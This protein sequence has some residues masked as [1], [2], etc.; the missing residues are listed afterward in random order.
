MAIG[1]RRAMEVDLAHIHA[2]ALRYDR[3]YSI[4]SLDTDFFKKYND[5]YGHAGGDGALRYT[6]DYLKAHVRKSDRIYRYGGE[7]VLLV[8]PQ[9]PVA[10]A[11]GLARRL[12][13][14]LDD[15]AEPHAESDDK[16][17]GWSSDCGRE[18]L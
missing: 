5:H 17:R 8:L 6:G 4:V 1:N 10:D 9:A 12:V 2:E 13:S 16:R 3:V 14:G 18:Q 11:L 15:L 7:E